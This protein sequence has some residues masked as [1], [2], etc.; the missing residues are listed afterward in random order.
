MTELGAHH[1]VDHSKPLA[2]Q[3]AA[4]GLG[5]PAFVFSTAQTQ[6][7]LDEIGEF[8]AP[9]GRFGLIDDP[10]ALDILGFKRKAISIHWESMFARSMFETA[11][12][13]E[14]GKLLDVVASLV[15][16]GKIR[17]TATEILQPINA[18]NVKQ[19]HAIIETGRAMGKVVLKGF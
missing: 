18:E 17:T 11:D 7:H 4:L 12:M 1:V 8:I 3:I 10:E 6:H 5:E 2:A 14:Q 19:A 9:Q 15:D 13:E 16:E